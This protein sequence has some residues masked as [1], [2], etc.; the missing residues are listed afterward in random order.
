MNTYI[1]LIDKYKNLN[2]DAYVI[3]CGP[4]LYSIYKDKE[5]WNKINN[6]KNIIC[7]VNSSIILFD[8]SKENND[9][10]WISND[11]LCRR[12]DW[13]LK[14]KRSECIKIVRNSWE[15]Y[16][17][18]L[19][20][21][22]FFEPRKTSE[23]IV[24]IEEKFLVYCCSI[25]SAIDLMIQ[26]GCKNI[27]ILGL[28]HNTI[29]NKHH[30]WQFFPKEKQPKAIIPAQGSW[31]QQKSVFPIHLKAY[32]ALQKFAD[33]KNCKIFNCNLDS[34]VDIFEKKNL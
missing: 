9:K 16:K 4:S 29:D 1:Q 20:N 24:N 25:G 19:D 26:L 10:Y 21:F 15:K 8:W 22:L 28:D 23:D 11:S 30:F 14:V 33:Y 17:N 31:K 7:S 18:E 6:E 3:G 2:K 32:K 27:F 12:W 34:R 13:W 5:L